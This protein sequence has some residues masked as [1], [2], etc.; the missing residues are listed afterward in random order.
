MAKPKSFRP[1]VPEQTL[2][3]PPSP[4]NWL[5]ADHLMFFMLELPNEL[6]F[7]AFLAPSR[8]KDRCGE[9]G[10]DHQAH[11]RGRVH[12][13]QE[14]RAVPRLEARGPNQGWS[15]V[16]TYLPTSVRGVWRYLY[17]V[18]DIWSRLPGRWPACRRH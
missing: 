17:L 12:P 7:E 8:H 4:V 11:H 13:P 18:V 5:P 6:D 16:I 3:L 9:K 10:F 14:P 1:W 15:W 2:L